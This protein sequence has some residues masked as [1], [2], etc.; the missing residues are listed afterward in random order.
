MSLENAIEVIMGSNIGTTFT[1]WI[2]AILGF[3]TKIESVALPYA[4]ETISGLQADS[5]NLY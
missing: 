4:R 3:K 2:V 5:Y 1:A